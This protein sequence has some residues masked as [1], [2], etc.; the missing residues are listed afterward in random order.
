[1]SVEELK[2][3]LRESSRLTVEGVARARL[4]TDEHRRGELHLELCKLVEKH[5]FED[6]EWMLDVIREDIR[7]GHFIASASAP[8]TAPESTDQSKEPT[9]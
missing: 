4:T 5:S 9:R 7:E 6:V 8:Q 2:R 1:M 3:A